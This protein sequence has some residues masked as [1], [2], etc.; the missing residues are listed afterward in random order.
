MS[1]YFTSGTKREDSCIDINMFVTNINM[2][3]TH[4]ILNLLDE[5][6]EVR[7]TFLDNTAKGC[8][9]A[10]HKGLTNQVEAIVGAG[11]N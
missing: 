6:L 10:W 11:S 7:G 9:K 1:N 4:N 3:A 2:F 8:I 5:A